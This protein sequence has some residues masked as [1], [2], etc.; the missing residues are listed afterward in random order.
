MNDLDQ[1]IQRAFQ[2]TSLILVFVTVL[3]GLRYPQIQDDIEEEIPAGQDAKKRLRKKLC[4]SLLVNCGPLLLING[5][6]SYL[7]SPLFMRVLRR[8]RF[9]LWSFDFSRTSF[10][11][12]VVLVFVFFLWS[13]YLAAQ[14]I[15]RIIKSQ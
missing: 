5:A 4:K 13:G 12:I 2:A 7:F 6:A 9:E 10:V 15:R 1:E 8:S 14:L 3:F 11:F